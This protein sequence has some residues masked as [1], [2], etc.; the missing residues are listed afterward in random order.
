LLETVVPLLNRSPERNTGLPGPGEGGADAKDE[1]WE[2]LRSKCDELSAVVLRAHDPGEAAKYVLRYLPKHFEF[3]FEQLFG[4]KRQPDLSGFDPARQRP[5]VESTA[6]N[7]DSPFEP[8]RTNGFHGNGQGGAW[9][10]CSPDRR[11]DA[12]LR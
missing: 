8:R 4:R 10:T 12:D 5:P 11:P 2:T 7:W 6:V 9:T 1:V 3:V